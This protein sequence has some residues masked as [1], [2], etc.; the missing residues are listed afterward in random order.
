MGAPHPATGRTGLRAKV[1]ACLL[2]AL[3]LPVGNVMSLRSERRSLLVVSVLVILLVVTLFFTTSLPD[4]PA[5]DVKPPD[6]KSPHIGLM[7]VPYSSAAGAYRAAAKFVEPLP[8]GAADGGAGAAKPTPAT[9]KRVQRQEAVEKEIESYLREKGVLRER[10]TRV[11]FR[12]SSNRFN[13]VLC[14][15]VG[16]AALAGYSVPVTT[17]ATPYT[18]IKRFT[19]YMDFVDR[20][21]LH[22]EDIVVTLDSDVYWTGVDFVPFLSKF[23]HLSP[24]K[25]SDLDVAAVRAW[26]DYGE[27][28]APLFMKELRAK[29][30]GTGPD[31]TRPLLQMPPVL[32]NSE[33]ECWWGQRAKGS[34]SCPLTFAALD[35]MIEVARNHVS[36]CNITMVNKYNEK[37]KGDARLQLHEAFTGPR[38]WMVDDMLGEPN[39]TSPYTT[40]ARRSHEDPL[41]YHTTVVNKAIPTAVL[42]SGLHVS[43]VWA[44]RH[45]VKALATF[46]EVEPPVDDD[47]HFKRPGWGCDQ[48]VMALIY[49]RTRLFEIEH[50]LLTGPPPALRTP[51]V[52]Y[53]PPHGPLGLIGLDR[54]SEIGILAISIESLSSLH[55]ESKYLAQ[56]IPETSGGR[57]L[58]KTER[59]LGSN[60]PQGTLP[61]EL[62]QTRGG[63]L[64]TPPL[65]WRSATAGDWARGFQC[66]TEEGVDTVF[67]PF[68]HYA[69]QNK[70]LYESHRHYYAWLVAARHD[71]RARASVT[72]TL[73]EELVELWFKDER[74]FVP[75]SDMCEDPTL[76][77]ES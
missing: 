40:Q 76:L 36:T 52:A 55:H 65:M 24:E 37:K 18:H 39:A 2:W 19:A 4:V 62:L 50:N 44:L 64:V 28:R 16:S 47:G 46:T 6:V 25:E 31:A 15:T 22:D 57:R 60:D 29:S 51:P 68:I 53:N 54:R 74:V 49:A 9:A 61:G 71:R 58:D 21:G 27:K 59:L 26:E 13:K 34:L 8:S 11:R 72:A 5:P 63:A 10:R 70:Q 7:K 42:N 33:D 32:F 35:H 17:V 20:E 14:R 1:K 3:R 66:D 38:R 48:A 45:M 41:F 30:G 67:S 43:R 23:A 56:L 12:T 69:S 75:F 73:K 77:S